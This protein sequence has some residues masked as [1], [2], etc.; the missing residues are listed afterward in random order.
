MISS[1][2]NTICHST[3]EMALYAYQY[4]SVLGQ[5]PIGSDHPY[6]IGVGTL[7]WAGICWWIPCCVVTGTCQLM[8]MRKW[9][10]SLLQVHFKRLHNGTHVPCSLQSPHSNGIGMITS[11]WNL[12]EN[13]MVPIRVPS[14]PYSTL[15]SV[16]M[17]F[18]V[19]ILQYNA[20][21]LKYK[22][23]FRIK[24]TKAQYLLRYIRWE[25]PFNVPS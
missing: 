1:P 4:R 13:R 18:I 20:Q 15:N 11:I 19:W 25:V 9:H 2:A 23:L 21:N 7:E 22:T 3:L 17:A 8:I 10:R 5:V 14:H 24:S 6:P 12:S 16:K